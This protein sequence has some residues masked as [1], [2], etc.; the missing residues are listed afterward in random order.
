M[1]FLYLFL[2]LAVK[3]N[4]YTV[5][6]FGRFKHC[7]LSTAAG[8]E[9]GWWPSFIANVN[10]G[11]GGVGQGKKA[12]IAQKTGVIRMWKRGGV[13]SVVLI[14]SWGLPSNTF[15]FGWFYNDRC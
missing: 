5:S 13:C 9:M 14:Q 12:R 11:G 2:N 10:L 15:P 1:N 7:M 6:S 3:S 4:S 8:P